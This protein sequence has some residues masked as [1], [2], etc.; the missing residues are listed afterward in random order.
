MMVWISFTRTRGGA[1]R[2]PALVSHPEV[3]LKRAV[4]AG[5][6]MEGRAEDPI[7]DFLVI[8]DDPRLR[9]KG[10][11]AIAEPEFVCDLL[12]VLGTASTPQ[13]E[14]RTIRFE[15]PDM[16]DHFRN[17]NSSGANRS[18]QSVVDIDVDDRAH[19]LQ[20]LIQSKSRDD[21]SKRRMPLGF[22]PRG[23]ASSSMPVLKCSAKFRWRGQFSN[24]DICASLRL[25]G[26]ASQK[27]KQLDA[28]GCHNYGFVL[29]N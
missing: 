2:H 29:S 11:E 8:D 13:I 20:R 15:L 14:F 7:S 17:G 16:R 10:L 9:K 4:G 5:G 21:Q 18:N 23:F 3:I 22:P 28:L 26:R 6:G 27:F 12:A 24:S 19:E 1:C 25:G